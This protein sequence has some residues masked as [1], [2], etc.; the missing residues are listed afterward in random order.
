M[1]RA[2]ATGV[3]KPTRS[4]TAQL[5]A[6]SGSV[7]IAPRHRTTATLQA[8]LHHQNALKSAVCSGQTL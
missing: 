2:N 3:I 4:K 1:H 8:D 7:E 5:L 6:L